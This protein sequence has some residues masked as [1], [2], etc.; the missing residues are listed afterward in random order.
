MRI[1]SPHVLCSV[2]TLALA[3]FPGSALAQ[4]DD[5]SDGAPIRC[6]EI[7]DAQ[8]RADCV[9]AIAGTQDSQAAEADQGNILVTGSRIRRPNLQS[10]VP[11]TSVGSEE[12]LDG[13][14]LNLGDALSQL[15]SLRGTFTQAN[16][17]RFIGTAG[18]NLLDLRGLGTDRTLVLVNGRRH[19]TSAPG[20]TSV[21]INN[22]PI[23]LLERVDVVTGGNSAIYGSDAVSGV[24]NFIL[25]RDYEGI[26]LRGQ[27]GISS[28]GD[29]ATQFVSGIWGTN[30][31]DDRANVAVAVEY[32]RSHRLMFADR[33]Y[34]GTFDGAPA[35]VACEPQTGPFVEPPA[36][37]GIPDT[38][39]F[40]PGPRF[41]NISLTGSRN[42]SAPA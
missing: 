8:Q 10:T 30:F 7:Q 12:V 24:V 9:T 14:N 15:P 6:A 4:D 40:D 37:D 23:D 28:R 26:G 27:L 5:A 19:V 2:S 22:I 35:F 20:S 17:T 13:G 34:Y 25:R 29:R 39:F 1:F 21:D 33:P 32:A 3:M 38:C 18:L 36:G 41:N 42:A 31:A 11:I 16:S